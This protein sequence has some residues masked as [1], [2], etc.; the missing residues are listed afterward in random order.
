MRQNELIAN[1]TLQGPGAHYIHLD[2]LGIING[3]QFL[4]GHDRHGDAI[5]TEDC[6]SQKMA[7]KPTIEIWKFPI[8]EV[9]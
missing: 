9:W 4:D 6:G 1:G 3:T 2:S 7:I 8:H 5:D